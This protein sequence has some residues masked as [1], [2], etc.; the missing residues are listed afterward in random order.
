MK[1]FRCEGNLP[2]SG[3][4]WGVSSVI[5]EG[6]LEVGRNGQSVVEHRLS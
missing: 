1:V 3:K 4:L 2:Y 5:V 6:L